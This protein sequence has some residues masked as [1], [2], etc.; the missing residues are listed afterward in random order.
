MWLNLSD[1]SGAIHSD[2]TGSLR[3]P[4][5][6]SQCRELDVFNRDAWPRYWGT[7]SNNRF[8]LS[9]LG[10]SVRGSQHLII[11]GRIYEQNSKTILAIWPTPNVNQ[12][13]ALFFFVGLLIFLFIK[14]SFITLIPITALIIAS[15]IEF[16]KSR[17][18][19]K[20]FQR[21][22]LEEL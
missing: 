7:V 4:Y 18:E 22:V 15:I 2:A 9:K 5:S 13:V 3:P 14:W 12:C 8:Q 17:E 19:Y 6:V 20:E 1:F 16:N 11:S 21:F 10:K